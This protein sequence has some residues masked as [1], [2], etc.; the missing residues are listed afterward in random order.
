MVR[1]CDPP[2]LEALSSIHNLK[3]CQAVVAGTHIMWPVTVQFKIFPFL[4]GGN[5]LN[6]S[7][8]KCLENLASHYF[9]TSKY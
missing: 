3:T 2:Y 8:D 5:I 9:M 1:S 6:V 7:F 4:M